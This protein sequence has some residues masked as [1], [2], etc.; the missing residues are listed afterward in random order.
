MAAESEPLLRSSCY[1]PIRPFGN[2]ANG[3]T[4]PSLDVFAT[5]S[6]DHG[7][8]WTTPVK[9]TDTMSN[10]NYEQFDNRALPFGGD[11]LTITGFGSFSFGTWTDWR[12]TVQGSDPRETTEDQDATSSDVVQCRDV[13]TST[14]KKGNT[15][16]SWSG[17]LCPHAGGLDQ[18]IYGDTTP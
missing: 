11:Y 14:D 6:S 7:V 5:T 8:S 3:T 16:K 2:C 15:I 4:V 9:L 10:G 17:D 13:L 1:S 18:N 12:N